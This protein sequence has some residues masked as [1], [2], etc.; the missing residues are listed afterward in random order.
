MTPRATEI[1]LIQIGRAA[2]G[3]DDATYR[4]MLRNLCDG[5]TSSKDLS[6]S[7]R[8][9]VLK[10]MK[11][12]GFV[13]KPKAGSPAA[14]EAGWQRAPQMR[15]LRAMWYA[16]AERGHVDRPADTAACNAAI[17]SWA[18]RHLAA[19]L[20]L[21]AL[22]FATGPQMDALIEAMKRWCTRLGVPLA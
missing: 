22:R 1:K 18:K 6:D 3:L 13:V 11:A 9:V 21:E 17:E 10:H 12:R 4:Q 8:Q 14:A 5:K 7:Q 2:L 19:T 16:M 15:K 20:P